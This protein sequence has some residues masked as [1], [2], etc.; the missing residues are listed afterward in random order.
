MKTY[1]FNTQFEIQASN[2]E[3]AYQ[4]LMNDISP[5]QSDSRETKLFGS[6]LVEVRD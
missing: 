6:E 4:Q 3:E 5:I 1:I 2:S